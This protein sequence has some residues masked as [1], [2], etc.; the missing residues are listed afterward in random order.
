[1]ALNLLSHQLWLVRYPDWLWQAVTAIPRRGRADLCRLPAKRL[2]RVSRIA[3]GLAWRPG[4]AR[5]RSAAPAPSAVRRAALG[6]IRRLRVGATSHADRGP[7]R[8]TRAIWGGS[9]ASRAATRSLTPP[10]CF[11]RSR[12]PVRRSGPIATGSVAG[13]PNSRSDRR[14][15]RR[16]GVVATGL[17]VCGLSRLGVG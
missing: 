15:L 10:E 11:S 17:N 8:R 3:A 9:C 5:P 16:V 6:S 4:L 14:L 12:R 13:S 7:S 2:P 1:M